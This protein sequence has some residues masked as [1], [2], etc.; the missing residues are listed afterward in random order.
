MRVVTLAMGA[1]R[2]LVRVRVSMVALTDM[3]G[4][5]LLAFAEADA[6]LELGGGLAGG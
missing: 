3:P 2:V 1:A 5:E 6:D 4:A